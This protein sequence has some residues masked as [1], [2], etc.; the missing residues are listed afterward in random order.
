MF[1]DG[2]YAAPGVRHKG[3]FER[4][5]IEYAPILIVHPGS[6]G[7]QYLNFLFRSVEQSHYLNLRYVGS[8]SFLLLSHDLTSLSQD[9]FFLC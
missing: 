9:R 5:H 4:F 8:V 3:S 2:L 7:E 1:A 6:S